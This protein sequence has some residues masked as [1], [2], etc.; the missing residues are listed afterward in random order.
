MSRSAS[1]T[2]H[3]PQS[4]TLVIPIDGFDWSEP[5][6]ADSHTPPS[7][8]GLCWVVCNRTLF[9]LSPPGPQRGGSDPTRRRPSA[10]P[11]GQV[12]PGGLGEDKCLLLLMATRRLPTY[13]H[14]H[15]HTKHM[16]CTHTSS[17]RNTGCGDSRGG[18]CITHFVFQV[19]FECALTS[20]HVHTHT[21]THTH[22]L[23]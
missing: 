3:G 16:F 8:R 11:G 4:S 1:V 13:T 19:S 18:G 17:K 23:I 9:F 21:H 22:A 6:G 20:L 12:W 14:T 15:T 2:P 5:G 7:I 10:L